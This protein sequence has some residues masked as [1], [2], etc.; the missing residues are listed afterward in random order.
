MQRVS[1]KVFLPIKLMSDVSSLTV[2]TA[3]FHKK[4]ILHTAQTFMR[5]IGS[6]ASDTMILS[7]LHPVIGEVSHIGRWLCPTWT[8]NAPFP[9]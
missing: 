7:Q 6:T 2:S 1:R 4:C 5:L 9:S 8:A 3:V